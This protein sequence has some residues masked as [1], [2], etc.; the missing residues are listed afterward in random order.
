MT[1]VQADLPPF[2][3]QQE[4]T[5]FLS[6]HFEIDIVV[7]PLLTPNRANSSDLSLLVKKIT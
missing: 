6:Q 3:P 1:F 4:R 2:E 5:T 7:V